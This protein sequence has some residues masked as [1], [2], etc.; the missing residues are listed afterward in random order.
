MSPINYSLLFKIFMAIL[1]IVVGLWSIR[2]KKK[3]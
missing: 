2:S 3:K 1:A